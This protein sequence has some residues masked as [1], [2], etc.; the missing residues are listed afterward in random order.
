MTVHTVSPRINVHALISENRLFWGCFEM[1]LCS[2]INACTFFSKN[3][4][5][6]IFSDF[7]AHYDTLN[8]SVISLFL[9][10]RVC[11]NSHLKLF[12]NVRFAVHTLY[13]MHPMLNYSHFYPVDT[14]LKKLVKS[15]SK[16][17]IKDI[18]S[19]DNAEKL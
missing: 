16:A 10:I 4:C 12:N 9:K 19:I 1:I 3:K 18:R 11:D 8:N 17:P 5:T 2:N 14:H 6:H 13:M 7:I 15:I